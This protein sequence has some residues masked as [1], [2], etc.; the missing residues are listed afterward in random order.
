MVDRYL[1]IDPHVFVA[2]DNAATKYG[3]LAL[4][5]VHNAAAIAKNIHRLN[6]GKKA[7]PYRPFKPISAV[8]L[9]R[10][11]AIIQYG[12]I[13]FDG[14]LGGLIR[15]LADLV[16]YADIMGYL[17]AL[18]LWLKKEAYEETCTRCR[19]QLVSESTD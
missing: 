12:P 15:R 19:S 10:N 1:Q 8:P 3:G 11:R 16:G 14:P 18:K 6:S 5:A 2:G 9:G 7:K 17:A 4:T 13:T